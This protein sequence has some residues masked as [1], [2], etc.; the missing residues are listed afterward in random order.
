MTFI[1]NLNSNRKIHAGH[2]L[3]YC[4]VGIKIDIVYLY[5]K[6]TGDYFCIHIVN[7]LN[8]YF[9][10]N[11][12]IILIYCTIGNSFVVATTCL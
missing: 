7:W 10:T 12:A 8:I 2:P 6:D 9:V 4:I 11:F 5:I 1:C 3:L